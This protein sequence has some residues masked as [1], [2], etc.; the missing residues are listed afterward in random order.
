MGVSNI[1]VKTGYIFCDGWV[2]SV[3]V[4]YS[5]GKGG[6]FWE[7][8]VYSGKFKSGYIVGGKSKFWYPKDTS[9]NHERGGGVDREREGYILR[10][11]NIDV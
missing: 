2:D 5:S 6:I 8:G 1:I 4:A 10:G 3:R 9:H 7:G 11:S